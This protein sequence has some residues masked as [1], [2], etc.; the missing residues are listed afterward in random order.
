[1]AS[2]PSRFGHALWRHR[3]P[4]DVQV[5][6]V[7]EVHDRFH[8]QEGVA[9]KLYSYR[10]SHG[11]THPIGRAYRWHVS[12]PLTVGAMRDAA[13]L[14][15]G[16]HDYTAFTHSHRGGESR[17]SAKAADKIAAHGYG[18]ASYRSGGLRSDDDATPPLRADVDRVGDGDAGVDAPK[19]F[20]N[21]RTVTRVD[22]VEVNGWE[23]VV[24]VEGPSF[25][26]GMVRNIVGTLVDVGSGVA[27]AADVP[28]MFRGG[29]RSGAGQGAPAHGLCLMW[30]RYHDSDTGEVGRK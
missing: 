1:M 26:H 19:P 27:A 22:V 18:A 3:L 16:T 29:R 5:V 21:V 23:V 2:S 8:P 25:T 11:E 4:E 10:L 14:F 30:V 20:D 7:E 24:E 17:A 12:K 28:A 6:A 15:V 9:A 13:A